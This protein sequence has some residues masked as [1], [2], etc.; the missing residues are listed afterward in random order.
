MFE[1]SNNPP[2]TGFEEPASRLIGIPVFYKLDILSAGD[3]GIQ[4]KLC[5][6]RCVQRSRSST[7]ET[8]MNPLHSDIKGCTLYE[9][10]FI[11]YI[12]G[13]SQ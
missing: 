9:S 6:T 4:R 2:I 13:E 7:S 12:E 8:P 5:Q 11:I 10:D 1:C 3:L